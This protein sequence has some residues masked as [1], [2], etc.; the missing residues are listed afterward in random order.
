MLL[1]EFLQHR[2]LLQALVGDGE[3][4]DDVQ[5]LERRQLGLSIRR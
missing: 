2:Q 5:L 4:T 3:A 1:L